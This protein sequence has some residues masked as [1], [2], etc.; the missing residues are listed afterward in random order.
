METCPRC[1]SSEIIKHGK[2][3]KEVMTKSGKKIYDVQKYC[4]GNMHIFRKKAPFSFSDSFIEY[5]VYIY[6]RCLSLNTTV[7]IIQATYEKEILSKSQVLDFLE[8]VADAMPTIDDI[9]DVLTPVRSGF[10]AVDGVWF[11]YGDDEI[12]L[13]VA[14]DPVSF[15]IVAAL[16]QDEENH[17]GYKT[18][19]QQVLTKVPKEKIIGMYGDGDA[20]LLQALKELLPAVPFQLCVV[21]KELRMGMLVPVKSVNISHRMDEEKK[22]AIRIFQRLYRSCIYADTKIQAKE[23]LTILKE[24][25]SQSPHE[26]FRKAYRSLSYNFDLTLSRQSK[27]NSINSQL[28]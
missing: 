22:E 14:F 6:L 13:L 16:W 11:Q 12:V 5:T 27:L 23:N 24:H 25:V 15:D 26:M 9:D 3:R 7:D 2:D 8:T 28:A 10:I 19:L 4:C 21:H 17:L 1:H 18:L 20:G